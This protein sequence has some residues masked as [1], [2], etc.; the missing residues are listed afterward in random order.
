MRWKRAFLYLLCFIFSLELLSSC[1]D[2]EEKK[3]SWSVNAYLS[4][5]QKETDCFG[6]KILSSDASVSMGG[7][8]YFGSV[9]LGDTEKVNE[10]CRVTFPTD[11]KIKNISFYLGSI[12]YQGAYKD[13]C[14]RVFVYI[15][16]TLVL[17]K[18]IYNHDVPTYHTVCVSGAKSVSFKTESENI[19]LAVGELLAWDCDV[20]TSEN[21]V[22]DEVLISKLVY[23][24]KPY[25]SSNEDNLVFAY[26][27]KGESVNAGGEEYTDAIDVYLPEIQKW[28]CEYFA[29]FNL[30]GKYS[31]ISFKALLSKIGEG[32]KETSDGENSQISQE[33]A[34]DDEDSQISQEKTS[35]DEDSQISQEETSDDEDSQISQE[36]TSDGE[37]SQI[38]QEKT[39]AIM[40]VYCDDVLVFNGEITDFSL[41][42]FDVSVQNCKK[43]CFVWQ[44]VPDS[45][46]AKLSVVGI[47]AEK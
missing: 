37:N 18:T 11:E 33:E 41:N 8:E 23:D 5:I 35:D 34:S 1:G 39:L 2:D 6:A 45:P 10:N 30:D 3:K 42:S 21:D 22:S 32:E 13:G 12:H 20:K 25:F 15:D 9:I 26:S 38:S 36:E 43:L 27:E 17:E 19:V 47:Y 14:E 16:E 24:I 4:D 44:S 7:K 28:S 40:Q 31:K 29:Y 46:A